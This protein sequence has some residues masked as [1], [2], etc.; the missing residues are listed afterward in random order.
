MYLSRR[1]CLDATYN[2]VV[3][4]ETRYDISGGDTIN[5]RI[6]LLQETSSLMKDQHNQRCMISLEEK[7][8]LGEK[9]GV[10]HQ[11]SSMG[12]SGWITFQDRT[13]TIAM[14]TDILV[15]GPY[16]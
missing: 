5:L 12:R 16:C 1:H 15:M 8:K 10:D 13:V 9:E 4:E 6:Y 3:W 11:V 14:L 7:A 2:G